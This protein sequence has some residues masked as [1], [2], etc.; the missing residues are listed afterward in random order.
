MSTGG[1]RVALWAA[2][3]DGNRHVDVGGPLWISSVSLSYVIAVVDLECPGHLSWVA[4]RLEQRLINACIDGMP[5]A[6]GITQPVA[7]GSQ[8]DVEAMLEE[9]DIALCSDPDLETFQL[10]GTAEFLPS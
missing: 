10:T 5:D 1:W 9:L 4:D 3:H 6:N 7:D 2:D 8:Q